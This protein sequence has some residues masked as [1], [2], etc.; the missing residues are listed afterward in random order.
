MEEEHKNRLSDFTE[1]VSKLLGT[2]PTN[3]REVIDNNPNE[4]DVEGVYAISTPDDDLVYVGKTRTKTISGRIKDH[5]YM[6]ERSDLRGMLK[7]FN[8]YP[9]EID[10]YLVRC[11]EVADPR[12][13]TFFEYFTIGVLSPPFNK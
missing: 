5:R 6:G 1:R 10:K 9:Q 2:T 8:D 4:F 11:I 12:E 3:V 13:R 7:V